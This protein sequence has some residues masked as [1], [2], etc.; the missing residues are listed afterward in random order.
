[1]WHLKAIAS[2]DLSVADDGQLPAEADRLE[3][4][5]FEYTATVNGSQPFEVQLS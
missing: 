1:M 3:E 5:E 4:I 2:R